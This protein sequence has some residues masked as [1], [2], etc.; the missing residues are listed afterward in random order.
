MAVNQDPETAWTGV[1]FLRDYNPYRFQGQ[2]NPAFKE[3][4]DGRLLD[5]KDNLDKGVA[6]A[7]EDF[8]EGLDK[9]DLPDGTVLVIVPGH[10]ALESNKKRALARAAHALAKLDKRYVASADSLI[11]TKTV[12]KKTDTGIRDVNVDLNS[13]TVTNPAELKGKIVV[14]LDDTTTTGGS[15]TAARQLLERAGAKRVAAIAIGRTVKYF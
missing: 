2:V 5:L 11:R 13:I 14:A 4:T 6:A 12:P 10:E 1:Y 7:A 3:A 15:L 8:K 9:L